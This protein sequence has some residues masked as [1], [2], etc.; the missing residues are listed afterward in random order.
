MLNI[1]LGSDDFGKK[2]YIDTLALT[3]KAEVDFLVQPES[4]D[5]GKLGGQ[6]LFAVKKI[7]V[8][9]DALQLVNESNLQALIDSSNKIFLNALKV[10][11]RSTFNKSLLSNKSITVKDFPLPHGK[12]LDKWIGRRVGELGGKINAAAIDLL[13]VYMGRD[14]AR[15]TKFGGKVVEVVEIFS[16]LDAN[17]EIKKLIAYSGGQEISQQM[18]KDL[19]PQ[20]KETDVLDIVNAIGE[21]NRPESHRLMEIFLA[22]ETVADEK[23]KIIQLNALLSEQFRNVA[24]VQ[25][26]LQ[27]RVPESQIL[28]QTQ[29]RAGRLFVIK[30]IASKFQAKKVL[31]L[32]NKLS[33]LDGELKTSNTPPRVLLDLIFSQL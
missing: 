18:V 31:D 29:W 19:V 3:D 17:N 5:M 32:L 20:R 23:G 14:E 2:Q 33:H 21:N 1:L 12:E 11:K 10:D 27:R 30:K 9:S 26:F 15:E 7:F 4:L 22:S 28:D 25:D 8:L 16:L 13:A 24:M 6:D